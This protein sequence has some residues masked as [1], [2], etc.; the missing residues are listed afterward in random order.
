MFKGSTASSAYEVKSESP[1]DDVLSKLR[2]P[3]KECTDD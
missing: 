2:E 3:I 1:L